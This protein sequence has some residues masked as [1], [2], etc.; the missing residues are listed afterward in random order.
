V[1]SEELTG[2]TNRDRW[3]DVSGSWGA[4]NPERS[5]IA[6]KH[7]TRGSRLLDLGAGTMLLKALLSENCEYQPCDLFSRCPGCIVAGF[8]KGEFPIKE[9][10]DWVTLIGLLQ[11]LDEPMVLMKKCNRIAENAVVTYSPIIHRR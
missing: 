1:N 10:Y 11:F 4:R 5:K 7:I 2:G 3:V 6:A 9:Q 8:N